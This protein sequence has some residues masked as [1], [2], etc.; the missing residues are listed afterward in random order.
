MRYLSKISFSLILSLWVISVGANERT[1]SPQISPLQQS[2]TALTPTKINKNTLMIRVNGADTTY[3]SNLPT[4][5]VFAP[6]KFKN[7]RQEQFYWRTVR[8]V[9]K[10]L[11]YAKLITHEMLRTNAALAKIPSK[12]E[13]KKY[14]NEQEKELFKKYKKTFT[15]MTISQGAMLMKLI[16]RECNRTSYDLIKFY[17][18]GV[19]AWF[20]QGIAKMFG[21]DLK[22]EYDVDDKDKIIERVI[23]LVESGQL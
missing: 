10:T 11:P 12:R 6:F 5:Q 1:N 14:M 15:R 3:Y 21:N 2:S 13:Q 20:W 7:K 16:E 18:G 19:S 17:R 9:K 23:I 22:V 4:L 8:D